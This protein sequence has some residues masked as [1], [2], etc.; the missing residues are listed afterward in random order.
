MTNDVSTRT[1]PLGDL[2]L[3]PRSVAIVGASSNPNALGGRPLG[4][5]QAYGYA[6]SLYAVNP[7]HA[8]VQGVPAYPSIGEVPETV[9]LALVVVRAEL[10]PDT[11]RQCVEA[12]VGVA[13]VISSGFG[14]GTGLGA[15]LAERAREAVAGSDMR[16]MGPNC[17]GIAVLS[18]DAP[19]TFSPVLDIHRSGGRLKEGGISIVAQSGGLGFAVS[20]WGTEVG[21]GYNAIVTTGNEM[22]IDQLEIAAELVDDPRTEVLVLLME[23]VED[24]DRLAEIA[25]AYRAAGKPLVVAKMGGSEAGRR[26]ALAHTCHDTG[27]EAAYAA[28]FEENGIV[29]VESMEELIDALQML[30]KSTAAAG[31]RVGIATTSGG[32]GVWLADACAARGL[33]VPILS[34][35]VQREMAALMPA[36][37]SP[38]G[39]VDLTAQFLTGGSFV[40]PVEILGRSGEVDMVVLAT[41][42]ASSGRLDGDRDNLIRLREECPVPIVLLTY[43]KPAPGT[44]EILNE[45][46]IPWFTDAAR[47]ARGLA[48]L[49][50]RN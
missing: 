11:L 30:T 29:R 15:D 18:S 5:L 4:F 16:I 27:E 33:D 41:S 25:Q 34:E 14:E 7:N 24:L 6:G 42:L 3:R 2:L 10:V 12:G 8:V 17:E 20:Q 36:Y 28:V 49:Q 9:D 43:T 21:L 47:A 26:G 38:V 19:V 44:I 22:D 37:G 1:R 46:G 50:G 31:N 13:I 40:P 45:I 39:P 23:G 35:G 32:T 48:M